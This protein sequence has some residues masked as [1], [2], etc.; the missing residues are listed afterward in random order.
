MTD[1][2]E[3]DRR[4]GREHWLLRSEADLFD[5]FVVSGARDC[6]L[7]E[8]RVPAGETKA[9]WRAH[10]R[11]LRSLRDRAAR[12]RRETAISNLKKKG[13]VNEKEDVRA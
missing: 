10:V 9:H 6:K 13:C 11:R 4:L 1:L 3:I 8:Q 12:S 7:C 2:A 5:S